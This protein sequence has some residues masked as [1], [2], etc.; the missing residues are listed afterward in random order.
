MDGFVADDIS[1]LGTLYI[2]PDYILTRF[3]WDFNMHSLQALVVWNLL[4][5]FIYSGSI[6][7]CLLKLLLMVTQIDDQTVQT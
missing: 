1:L 3:V 7:Q 2:L 4:Q 5:K 6:T